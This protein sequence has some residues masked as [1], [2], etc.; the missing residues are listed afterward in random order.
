MADRAP[1][2]PEAR[3]GWAAGRAAGLAVGWPGLAAKATCWAALL[4]GLLGGPLACWA[5]GV[6]NTS[7]IYSCTDA[8]GRRITADRPI[9]ECLDREQKE[10]SPAGGVKRTLTPSLTADERATLEV[11]A[12]QNA[13]QQAK[14][15]EERRQDRALLARYPSA[16]THQRERTR[17]LAAQQQGQGVID[18]HTQQLQRERDT[19]LTEME[20]YAADP[21]KAPA[22]LR[23]RLQDSADQLAGQR[24]RTAVLQ[25][26]AA[27]LNA[28]FDEELQ[29]LQRLW[30][31]PA[32]T[33]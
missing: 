20:F 19:L 6:P 26:E 29:R 9:R 11:K 5:Q 7:G 31:A 21:S 18:Q 3:G 23:Q 24:R 27:R 22:M 16:Q 15:Q 32:G 25:E 8:Q 1:C 2:A 10:L 12:K 14:A 33:R 30:A 17:Q 13:A 28:R 4:G